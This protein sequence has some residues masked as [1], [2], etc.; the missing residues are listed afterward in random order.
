MKKKTLWI[1]ILAALAA[2]IAICVAL[3]LDRKNTES[4]PTESTPSWEQRVAEQQYAVAASDALMHYFHNNGYVTDYPDYYGGGYIEDGVYHIR[5]CSPLEETMAE[6]KMVLSVYSPVVAYESCEYSLNASQKYADTVAKEMLD[7]EFGVT[8]W[9]VSNRTGN[10][11][12]AVVAED[13]EAAEKFIKK[14]QEKGYPP[15]IITE[16]NYI[17]LH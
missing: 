6:L 10:I 7:K 2:G 9:H 12:I 8:S 13:M 11:E 1:L 14:R 3:T 16:G 4:D 5:L 17:E 15:I